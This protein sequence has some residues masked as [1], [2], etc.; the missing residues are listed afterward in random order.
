MAF[1]RAKPEEWPGLAE[2]VGAAPALLWAT[3]ATGAEAGQPNGL[4]LHLVEG[5]CRQIG[6]RR[7]LEGGRVHIV[8]LPQEHG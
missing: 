3:D 8:P 6:A 5:L 2:L 1:N 7:R 4:C